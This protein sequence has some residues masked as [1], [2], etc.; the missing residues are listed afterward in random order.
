MDYKQMISNLMSGIIPFTDKDKKEMSD[1]VM[2]ILKQGY[3]GVYDKEPICDII[4]ICNIIYNNAPNELSPLDDDLY[5]RLIVL[6]KRD[7]IDYPI[8]AP[9]VQFKTNSN[10]EIDNSYSGPKTVIDFVPGYQNMYYFKDLTRNQYPVYGDFVRSEYTDGKE[11]IRQRTSPHNYDMCGTLDKCKFVLNKDSPN[12]NDPTISIF[13]RDFLGKHITRGIIDQNNIVLLASLKYDG[14]SVEA[15]IKGDKLV[16]A[17]TRGDI[18]SNQA[19]D[20][21]PVLEGMVFPRATGKVDPNETFGVKFEFII[22]TRNLAIAASEYQ[23]N[24][25]NPRNA[26]IGLLGRLDSYKFRDLLIPVPLESSIKIVPQNLEHRIYPRLLELDFLNSYYTRGID[27]R[28][29]VISGTY[30]EVLYKLKTLVEEADTLRAYSEF[31]Y[32]GIVVEYLEPSIREVLGKTRSVPNYAVAIKFP[33]MKRTSTFTHYTY[34]VGQTGV[35]VPKAHF[36]PVEF[37]GQMHDKTTVH[38]LKRFRELALRV[39]DSVDLTLNNDVI[40]YLTKSQNQQPNTNPLEQFPNVCPSCGSALVLSESGDSAM[41]PNFMCKERCIQRLSGMLSK[42]NIKNIATETIRALN[43]HNLSELL[44]ITKEYAQRV[45]GDVKG[46]NIYYI[47]HNDL[48]GSI[49]L[50]YQLV[51]SIGFTGIAARTWKQIL[52]KIKIRDLLDMSDQELDCLLSI[53][54]IGIKTVDTIKLERRY[55]RSELE[56]IWSMYEH[57]QVKLSTM[58]TGKE[59]RF[60]GIRDQ[61]LANQLESHGYDVSMESGITEKTEILIV[62][63]RGY[64]SNTVRKAMKILNKRLKNANQTFEVTDYQGI[65]Q[66]NSL[67]F[68][69]IVYPLDEVVQNINLLG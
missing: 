45:L 31:Q 3:I 28:Y 34:S 42:L 30:V 29:S 41:C 58:N 69:P 9:P 18:E 67:G 15:T 53:P 40:V 61:T 26:V 51:G 14:I 1:Y 66:A 16:S 17:C 33:P 47:I 21:T 44:S 24:Y 63:Y 35:I 64:D 25:V 54:G 23:L 5:D 6:C 60:S 55:F 48:L 20:L 2:R 68:K 62:P 36:L 19:T 11:L 7:S 4:R 13:E 8:G 46:N 43:I 56:W 59:V 65:L 57:N 37:M 38:S 49:Y 32:D 12:I 39:G 10:L 22:N 27:M 52:G 50:D